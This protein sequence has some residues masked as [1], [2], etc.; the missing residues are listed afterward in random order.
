MCGHRVE[1]RF[2]WDCHGLPVEFEIE[3]QL[4]LNGRADIEK[5]GIGK[6]NEACRS[7]VLRY[8]DEWQQTVTRFG[9]WVD[10]DND[11]KTM[12]LSFMESVWSV[13][14]TLWDR[15]LIYEGYRVVP[16]SWR[17]G[18]PLSN[19]EANL[20][21][22]EIQDPSITV[23]FRA[24]DGL[25]L[26]AWTT[27]P[28]TLPS[29]LGLAVD[30]DA[31]YAIVEEI[32]THGEPKGERMAMHAERVAAYWPADEGIRRV[33][34]IRG[35]ELVGKSYEPLFSVLRRAQARGRV[36]RATGDLRH[37]REWHGHRAHRAGVRRGRFRP[38]PGVRHRTGRSGGCGGL[39][40]G[41]SPSLRRPDGEGRRQA[42]HQRSQG[43]WE[44]PAPRHLRP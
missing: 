19:F 6:F 21:Y 11:Y 14:K 44:D 9:R 4:G 16:Y 37:R 26:L 31:D 25:V 39:L 2:G 35:S 38:G 15:D 33:D 32:D 1:R 43:S 3:K 8:T 20:N 27:T 18:A 22:K 41:A 7:I 36:P 10:F 40:H 42:D 30:P 13:F 24:D 12:D 5:Y 29:N 28:W 17:I 34:T 23:K